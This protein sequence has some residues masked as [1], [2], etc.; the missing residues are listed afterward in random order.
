MTGLS[1]RGALD[2][3]TVA[4]CHLPARATADPAV[5]ARTRQA[6]DAYARAWE[7]GD[8]PALL[9]C[10]PADFTLN[11]FGRNA[12]AGRHAGKAAAVEAQGE[13]R[14]RTGRQLLPSGRCSME[15]V[16]MHLGLVSRT[17][18]R[19]LAGMGLR[20]GRAEAT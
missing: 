5:E 17:V 7:K 20:Y 18:P 10:Y 15:Q 2:A 14:R 11:W 16:A 6:I 19:R 3:A 9:A 12:L 1:R 8:V 4:L 13:M